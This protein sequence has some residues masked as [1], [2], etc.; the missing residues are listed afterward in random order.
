MST[1]TFIENLE[2]VNAAVSQH[3]DFK[4]QLGREPDFIMAADCVVG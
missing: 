3:C 2:H 4:L 1:P